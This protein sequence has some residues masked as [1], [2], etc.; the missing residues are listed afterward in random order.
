MAESVKVA[1]RVRPF[2]EREKNRNATVIIN[3]TGNQTEIK[4]PE[5]LSADPRRF[6]FDFSY[7]SHDEF[8]ERPDGYLEP[9]G[10]KYADQQTVFNDL[11]KGII[12][13]AWKGYNC[14]LF[15]YGQTGSG[16]SYSVVGYGKN[17]GIVPLFCDDLFDGI[18]K[19]RATAG[20]N[21]EYQVSLSMLEIYNE[22]V[23]D[24][25][26]PK[27]M[28]VKG[29]LKV[30]Q[31]PKKGFY[32]EQMTSKQVNSYEEID[33]KINEGTRNR[34]V[35]STNMNA[36]SSR[37]HTIIGINFT[38]KC[39]ND[40]GE[41]M[42]RTAVVN[43]V[44]LAGSE[45]ADST[46]ATGDRLKEGSAINKSLSTL[47]NVIKALA[48]LSTG[49]K[50][51]VVPYRDSTL[52][53]LLQNALG[54][55]SK[56]I[57]IAALS[58]ADINYEETLSTLRFADRAKA[59]K[60]VA[61]V[62]E[63]PTDKLI[64]ELRE[65]NAKLMDMIKSGGI[66]LPIG[67]GGGGGGYTTDEV[68][69]MKRQLQE[70]LNQ[71]QSEMEQMKKSWQQKLAESEQENLGKL[72]ED[73]K[74]NEDRKVIP[75]FWNLNEDPALTAMVIH[76]CN[77][78]KSTIGTK[79]AQPPPN[80][81]I[82]GL[83]IQKQHAIVTNKGMNVTLEPC[84][85]AKILVNGQKIAKGVQLHHNDRVL[86]GPNHLYVFHHPKDASKAMKEGKSEETPTFDSANEEIAEKAGLVRHDGATSEDV[87]LQEEV[88]QLLPMVN[89][90]N[91]MSDELKKKVQFEL[92]L[93]SP[94]AR[95]LKDGKT[96]VMVK[97]LNPQTGNEWM[98]DRNKF[99]NR[100][101]LMQE[102]Y[103]NYIEGDDD[104]DLPQEKDPFWE[105]AD[106]ELLLGTVHLHLMSVAHKLDSE[107]TLTITNYKGV[108]LGHIECAIEPCSAKG[109]PLPEDDF[110]DSPDELIGQELHFKMKINHARGLPQNIAKSYCQ[111]K[112]YLDNEYVKT[113]EV[114]SMNPN[115]TH[116]KL[117]H[118]K[119]VTQ[120]LVGYLQDSAIVIEVWG[121]QKGE[122]G[123]KGTSAPIKAPAKVEK[124][125]QQTKKDVGPA[126]PAVA[127][128]AATVSNNDTQTKK[129]ADEVNMYKK[130][131]A[132]SEK[133]MTD[134]QQF[135]ANKK[136]QG[137]TQISIS[138]LES[139]LGGSVPPGG[140]GNNNSSACTVQ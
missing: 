48:D 54:G 76:F 23:R 86:F 83:S 33:S 124:K 39:P 115:F 58:P 91:A 98:W 70:Q 122:G 111:Y 72:E 25:L 46:G 89:E 15:A 134:V 94:Q 30:R 13:N 29:G 77:D 113:P 96:E 18:E 82:N 136:N 17:Q 110:V 104:W 102:M 93:I 32:V 88:V 12:D 92:A 51:V 107:E 127:A 74:K 66:S 1:V 95:G 109:G 119:P 97:M 24:L 16:K 84:S 106:T 140:G 36:T 112:V 11:G 20:E 126:K 73:K 19:K 99:I 3:M 121:R 49:N 45:R 41:S 56:T 71:N 139:L 138:D 69:E 6:S 117:F 101:F 63:S 14:S 133:K 123:S 27:T 131:A 55:N 85:G 59:I 35:A 105:P 129:M 53:K 22:Q 40:V 118:F 8:K 9:T 60:T 78:G 4:D 87:V 64:R 135:L 79:N 90:A 47:G 132:D 67:G 120:Q 21:E 52:T 28:S 31:D 62:N 68:E 37:A 57:M 108:E 130:K 116:E 34:T 61:T 114:E 75:H 100:K 10:T 125:E 26:N 42:T 80:I 7:W 43:L 137:V 44:D 103:Q 65:E 5:N 81:Q 2:N 128:S 38:Q 50:K